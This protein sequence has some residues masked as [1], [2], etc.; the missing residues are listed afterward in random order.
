MT[1]EIL[2][3]PSHVYEIHVRNRIKA[4]SNRMQRSTWNCRVCCIKPT[5]FVVL[6]D[7][8]FQ[9]S[10]RQFNNQQRNILFFNKQ[11]TYIILIKSKIITR[12]GIGTLADDVALFLGNGLLTNVSTKR[13]ILAV[14]PLQNGSYPHYLPSPTERYPPK[15]IT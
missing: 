6:T 14:L 1:E 15:L 12:S 7:M 9:Q 11:E 13:G 2:R 8:T 10:T 3:N 4:V 5:H